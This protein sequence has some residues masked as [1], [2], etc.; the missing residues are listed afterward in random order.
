MRE[1]TVTVLLSSYNGE[2]YIREQIESILQQKC[3]NVNLIVRDDGSLDQTVSI[4]KEY[5]L[6]GKLTLFCGKNCGY[7][8][9]FWNLLMLAPDSE[10]YAFADQDDVWL[11]NKLLR[12]VEQ[13]EKQP[14]LPQLYCANYYI[15]DE[16]LN[17]K[18]RQGRILSA[19]AWRPENF[20]ITQTPA[21]GNTMVWN[22]ALHSKLTAHPECDW[23][24]EHDHRMQFAA[25]MLGKITIDKERT[26]LYRQHSANVSGGNFREGI[27]VWWDIRKKLLRNRLYGDERHKHSNELRARNFLDAYR[28]ELDENMIENL[29]LV[30]DYRT[31]IRKTMKLLHSTVCRGMPFKV[32][33]R[34]LLHRV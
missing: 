9:S 31:S 1:K 8:N 34:V 13:L 21:L 2:K 33:I 20:I 6:Q 22:H 28:N 19:E 30:R 24:T 12:A 25:A 11:K 17:I 15:V 23:V 3:V 14:A 16:R 5:E 26:I 10:Y 7:V 4:L 29:E 32:R 18:K 27:S